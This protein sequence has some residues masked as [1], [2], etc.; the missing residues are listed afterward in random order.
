M[1]TNMTRPNTYIVLHKDRDREIYGFY[2][3]RCGMLIGFEYVLVGL[4]STSI[5]NHLHTCTK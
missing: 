5:S 1:C 2:G 3:N 4:A